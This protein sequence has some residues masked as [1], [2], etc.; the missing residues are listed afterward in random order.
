MGKGARDKM[1]RIPRPA[2]PTPGRASGEI[3]VPLQRRNVPQPDGTTTTEVSIDLNEAPIPERR[4]VAD[5]AWVD[6]RDDI[7]RFIFGQRAL[8]GEKLRSVVVVNV[9]PEV[10]RGLMGRSAEFLQKIHE[11]L[12]RNSLS[13]PANGSL[14]EEPAQ[15]VALSANMMSITFAGRE[16]EWDFFHLPPSGMRKIA[17]SAD[18]VVD[19]VVRIDLATRL[20]AGILQALER[21][22]PALPQ[23][24]K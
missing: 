7:I 2:T 12:E 14:P 15:T 20:V 17:D 10:I 11:F 9:Y 19:P 3:H 13:A 18:L 22:L 4:Y 24:A 16:A 21:L 6:Q 1:I 8:T 23:E 5:A